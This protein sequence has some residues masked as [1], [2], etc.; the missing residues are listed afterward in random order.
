[1]NQH[2]AQALNGVVAVLVAPFRHGSG[3]FDADRCTALTARVIGAGIPAVTA[4]GNTAE[5]YQLDGSEREAMLRA[6]ADGSDGAVRIAGLAGSASEVLRNADLAASLGYDAVMLHEPADPLTDDSGVRAYI[7]DLVERMPLP[8]VLYVRSGRLITGAVA[9]LAAHPAVVGVKYAVPDL[10]AL[11]ELMSDGIDCVWVNGAAESRVPATAGLGVRGFTS[12]LANVRPD[13]ALAVHAAAR[14]GDAAALAEVLEPILAFERL[15]N[16]DGG[17]HNVAVVKQA[18][19][20]SG[21]DVGD[22]RPP[23]LPAPGDEV[24]A[25]VAKLP[26]PA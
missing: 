13:L 14:D 2:L 8:T 3:P 17:R 25:I 23:S 18:L 20:L 10:A 22:V 5:V 11:Q 4:L 26:E 15:R 12:G 24:E 6:V 7:I 1:M 19:R 16:R 9:E 21:F